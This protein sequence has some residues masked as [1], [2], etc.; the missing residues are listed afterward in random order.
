MEY[1]FVMLPADARTI[2]DF[3]YEAEQVDWDGFCLGW[4]GVR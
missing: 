4:E 3:A 2:V 1:G